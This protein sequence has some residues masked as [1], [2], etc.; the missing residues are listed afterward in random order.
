MN[1]CVNLLRD[2]FTF[3]YYGNDRLNNII[4][5]IKEIQTFYLHTYY[6]MQS[7]GIES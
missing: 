4:F 5:K 2:C 7:G 3:S 6:L 1:F